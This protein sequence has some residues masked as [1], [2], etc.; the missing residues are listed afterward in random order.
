MGIR[1]LQNEAGASYTTSPGG[2]GGRA[3]EA[4]SLRAAH[5]FAS[6]DIGI[7]TEASPGPWPVSLLYL[8]AVGFHCCRAARVPCITLAPVSLGLQIRGVYLLVAG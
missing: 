3:G 5:S 1:R 4:L 2:D 6:P 8:P 7:R